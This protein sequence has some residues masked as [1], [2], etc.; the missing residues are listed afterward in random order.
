MVTF[1]GFDSL[2]GRVMERFSGAKYLSSFF[3]F[4]NPFVVYLERNLN[5][6]FSGTLRGLDIVFK[7]MQMAEKW[8]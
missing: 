8:I 4:I 3:F 1:E 2:Q 5:F 6:Y 7:T